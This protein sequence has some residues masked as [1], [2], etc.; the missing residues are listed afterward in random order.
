MK[1]EDELRARGAR[2][3]APATASTSPSFCRDLCMDWQEII[4]L[5][6]DPLVTIGAHTVNHMM[7][8]KWRTKPPCARRWR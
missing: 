1:T 8:K 5:A 4:E 3:R 7:L 6:A 2:S